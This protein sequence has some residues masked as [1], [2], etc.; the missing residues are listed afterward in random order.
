MDRTI[1]RSLV[2]VQQFDSVIALFGGYGDVCGSMV[3]V[4]FVE[5][6]EYCGEGGVI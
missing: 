4:T 3:M 1:D 6:R 5:T 2:C